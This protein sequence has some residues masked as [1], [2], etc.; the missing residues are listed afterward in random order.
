MRI[1]HLLDLPSN[2]GTLFQQLGQAVGQPREW[3]SAAVLPGPGST[4][5][6]PLRELGS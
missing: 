5:R 4:R 1:K 6:V 2:L 3:V